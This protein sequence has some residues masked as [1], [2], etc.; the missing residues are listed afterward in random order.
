MTVHKVKSV[1]YAISYCLSEGLVYG[2]SK[3]DG[4]LYVGPPDLLEKLDVD[5]AE[6]CLPEKCRH[7]QLDSRNFYY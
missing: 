1:P 4:C 5:I 3:H 6:E 7:S 2:V